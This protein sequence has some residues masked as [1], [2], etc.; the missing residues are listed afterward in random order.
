MVG[1]KFDMNLEGTK[2]GTVGDGDALKAA[3]RLEENNSKVDLTKEV[4]ESILPETLSDQV[5]V[6]T[7]SQELSQKFAI[8]TLNCPV[9]TKA[10]LHCGRVWVTDH[11]MRSKEGAELF[12]SEPLSL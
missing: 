3:V 7:L 1:N 6:G 11:P 9:G 12:N 2:K 5:T 10:L 8:V 4:L